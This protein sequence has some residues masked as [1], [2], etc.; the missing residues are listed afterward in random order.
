MRFAFSIT[1]T[2]SRRSAVFDPT[3]PGRPRTPRQPRSRNTEERILRAFGELLAESR[4]EDVSVQQVAGRAGVS[5]GGFYARFG[6]KDDAL[7]HLLYAG[8]VRD[9][10]QLAERVLDPARW[11]GAGIAPI[12]HAYFKLILDA[13]HDHNVVLRELVSRTRVNPDAVAGSDAWAAFRQGI[14][15]PF[16][17]LMAARMAEV[18]HADPAFALRFAFSACSSALRE[19]VL[20]GHMAPSMGPVDE[21]TLA[22]ELARMFCRYLGVPCTDA[23]LSRT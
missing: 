18:D 3:L 1:G 19:T 11:E 15:E 13:G 7:L 4:F 8:Y 5:V 16:R 21:A 20:F 23:D 10:L 6:S 2:R 17:Q 14:H 12:A 22:R 9:A